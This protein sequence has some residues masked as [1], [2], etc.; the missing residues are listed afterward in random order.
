MP[1]RRRNQ[2]PYGGKLSNSSQPESRSFLRRAVMSVPKP[3]KPSVMV[4]AR[5]DATNKRAGWPCGSFSQK[6]WA[7]VTAWS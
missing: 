2:A 6:T 1:K 3:L 5:S 4:N 7:S